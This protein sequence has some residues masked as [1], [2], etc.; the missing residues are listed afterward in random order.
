MPDP[1]FGT[2]KTGYC[3]LFVA[4]SLTPPPTTSVFG[5][6]RL[7]RESIDPLVVVAAPYVKQ[8]HQAAVSRSRSTPAYH[9]E[10]APYDHNPVW[11]G[12][13]RS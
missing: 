5:N 1:Q 2:S 13:F 7:C 6:S 3:S 10:N 12:L 9:E 8:V 11:Q 4:R